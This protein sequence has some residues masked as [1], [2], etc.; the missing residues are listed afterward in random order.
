[1]SEGPEYLRRLASPGK[2]CPESTVGIGGK[3]EEKIGGIFRAK[4]FISVVIEL[5][6]SLVGLLDCTIQLH[7]RIYACAYACTR[8]DVSAHSSGF[9]Q[10]VTQLGQ[11]LESTSSVCPFSR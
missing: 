3:G 8:V 4:S 7:H 9:L 1:M 2:E 10:K 6:S 11:V 5:Y